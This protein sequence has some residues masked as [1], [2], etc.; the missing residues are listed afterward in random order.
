MTMPQPLPLIEL[1]GDSHDWGLQHGGAAKDRVDHNVRAY[2]RRFT[3]WAR[4]PRDEVRDRAHAY[5][6]VIEVTSPGYARAIEGISQAS[7]QDLLDIVALNVRYEIMYSEF[8]E[9]GKMARLAGLVSGGCTSFAVLPDFSSNGHLL[10]GQN[11]DWIPESM[12]VVLRTRTERGLE[13][14]AF[15]EAGIAGAKIGFNSAGIGLTVN[16]LVSNLD[17]WSRLRKPFHVRCWEV[18]QSHTLDQADRAVAD[19]PRSCSANFLIALGGRSPRILDIEAAPENACRIVPRGSFLAHTNHFSDPDSLG[20]SQPL[21]EDRPS[22]FHRFARMQAMFDARIAQDKT[23]GIA[24]LKR[25]LRDHQG[26]PNSV[27]RHANLAFPPDDRYETVV[28]VV[29]DLDAKEMHIARGPPCTARYSR[30]LLR[31]RP[32]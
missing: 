30:I 13:G 1:T 18:L 9:R 3:E 12:G 27:C 24:D 4:I 29:M 19:E 6:R 8:A 25:T 7:G 16:G 15:T 17:S 31:P 26:E 22:T 28:S 20:I 14:L 11:W 5:W 23:I 21:G 2:L 32:S 10:M